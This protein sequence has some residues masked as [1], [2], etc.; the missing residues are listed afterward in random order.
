MLLDA[1]KKLEIVHTKEDD[2][3]SRL[4]LDGK[5]E[6]P[7]GNHILTIVPKVEQKI[8]IAWLLTA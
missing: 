5:D 6:I 2:I 7:S 3:C 8:I 1:A 4:H